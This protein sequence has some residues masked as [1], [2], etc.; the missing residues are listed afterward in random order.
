MLI[1]SWVLLV[2]IWAEIIP[3]RMY[4]FDVYYIDWEYERE[5]LT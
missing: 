3:M 2:V 5:Y 4:I 1:F